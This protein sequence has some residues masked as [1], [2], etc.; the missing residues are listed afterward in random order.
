MRGAVSP[1]G[2]HIENCALERVP[3]RARARA[4]GFKQILSMAGPK[5]LGITGPARAILHY[6]AEAPSAQ[7]ASPYGNLRAVVPIPLSSIV[8]LTTQRVRQEHHCVGCV[9]C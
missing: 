2:C 3:G 9:S 4:Q 1:E 8:E 6:C 7:G 5:F